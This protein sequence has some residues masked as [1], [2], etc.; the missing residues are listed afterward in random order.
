MYFI[1]RLYPARSDG[2]A[3]YLE[4]RQLHG[5]GRH[6]LAHALFEN[7]LTRGL[8]TRRLQ[9][10]ATRSAAVCAFV[11]GALEA[12]ERHARRLGEEALATPAE[13]AEANDMLARV[14]YRRALL[15][16]AKPR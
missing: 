8:P 1:E 6:D 15:R 10:E 9:V 16:D 14:A 5:A 12:A 4:A 13:Q 7:A 2:M 3:Y 11:I